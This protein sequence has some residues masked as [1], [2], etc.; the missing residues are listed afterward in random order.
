MFCRIN[1]DERHRDYHRFLWSDNPHD[2]PNIYRFKEASMGSIDSPFL[3]VITVHHHQD[4][5]VE[6]SP[7]LASAAD[8]IKRYLYVDDLI[9]A[10]DSIAETTKL[11]N[12]YKK[13]FVMM[14]IQITKWS[15]NS[16][17]ISQTIPKEGLSPYK[18]IRDTDITYGSPDIISQT[19]KCFGMKFCPKTDMSNYYSYEELSKLE[20][21][22][23]K[24]LQKEVFNPLFQ[25]YMTQQ[26]YY[27]PLNEKAR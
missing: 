16:A 14:K 9:G 15:S 23:L 24:L 19:T 2:K 27:S 10:T 11:K 20:G 8:F 13:I 22:A 25:E 7:K 21:K 5:I 26:D 18:N 17:E 3:E 4:K 6:T 1:L 12:I